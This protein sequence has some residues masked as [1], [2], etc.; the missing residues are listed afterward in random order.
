LKKANLQNLAS[1]VKWNPAPWEGD[2]L[3]ILGSYLRRKHDAYETI[4]DCCIDSIKWSEFPAHALEQY[5]MGDANYF[6]DLL[7]QPMPVSEKTKQIM[8]KA[9]ACRCQ[10][11]EQHL[12]FDING[13]TELPKESS[14]AGLFARIAQKGHNSVDVLLS[15]T[16]DCCKHSDPHEVLSTLHKNFGTSNQSSSNEPWIELKTTDC[17]IRPR[18]VG[19]RHG[20]VNSDRCQSFVVEA[21]F[22][23]SNWCPILIVSNTP[24][25]STE[26]ILQISEERFKDR[27]FNRFRIRMSGASSTNDWYLMVSWF[28]IFGSLGSYHLAVL[29]EETSASI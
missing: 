25:Q 11:L 10:N 13:S 20:W 3:R 21:A 14:T 8:V 16:H 29:D 26:Q 23:E 6:E 18:G 27:W 19:L 28:D 12:K 7:G 2:R 24:L 9:L 17:V 4:P 22:E 5:I 1:F 15:S